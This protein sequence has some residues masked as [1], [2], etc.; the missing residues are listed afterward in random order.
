MDSGEGGLKGEQ[1]NDI[2]QQL[3]LLNS[4][5]A[6]VGKGVEEVEER[7]KRLVR[8]SEVMMVRGGEK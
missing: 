1:K 8:G 4:N 6:K 2:Y 7:A 3:L 5:V